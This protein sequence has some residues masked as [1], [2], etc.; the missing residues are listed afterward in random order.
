MSEPTTSGEQRTCMVMEPTNPII[1]ALLLVMT[2]IFVLMV[3]VPAVEDFAFAYL[4]LNVGDVVAKH[5]Y[6]QAVTAMFLH[7]DR[8]HFAFNMAVLWF[9]G[10]A[11]AN[12]WRRTEFLAYYFFCGI[13]ASFCFYVACLWLAPAACGLGASGALFGLL[14]AYGMVFGDRTIMFF[15]IIPMKARYAVAVCMGASLLFLLAPRHRNLAEAAHLGGA[16]FGYLYLKTVWKMQDR[17]A[18]GGSGRRAPGSRIGGIEVM[19]R[20]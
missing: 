14:M 3:L 18:G 5:R 8:W 20:K 16:V 1:L 11:L 13:A 15:F 7:V 4:A 12:S 17:R 6:W 19:D 10:T 2:V 9:F